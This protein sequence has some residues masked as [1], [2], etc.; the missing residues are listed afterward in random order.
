[1][2]QACSSSLR[3]PDA[4]AVDHGRHA[5]CPVEHGLGRSANRSLDPPA[6]AFLALPLA[7]PDELAV[8]PTTVAPASRPA[9]ACDSSKR[10][11]HI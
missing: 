5:L 10:E 9:L 7:Q 2:R 8:R 4:K 11:P 1:M 6:F 3:R